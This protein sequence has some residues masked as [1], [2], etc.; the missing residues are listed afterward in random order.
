MKVDN[1]GYIVRQCPR[2]YFVKHQN[3]SAVH[4]CG[5]GTKDRWVNAD[6]DVIETHSRDAIDIVQSGV[7]TQ[8]RNTVVGRL[9]EPLTRVDTVPQMLEALGGERFL[10]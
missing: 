9:C 4:P 8:P 10:A 5:T 6:A 3:R 7:R 1:D 2:N